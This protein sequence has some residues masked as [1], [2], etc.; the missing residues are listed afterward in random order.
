VITVG[1]IGVGYWG[2]N[3]ANSF[4]AT[5]RATVAWACDTNS[6][7]LAAFAGRHPNIRPTADIKD[8]LKDSN[9]D[10]VAVVTPTV[11]HHA[12]AKAALTAGKHVLV[13]KP[14]TA[15]AAEAEEL[16]RI[17]DETKRVLMVGH[18]FQYNASIIALKE[19]I[20]AGELGDITYLY[21]ERTNLGPVRTDV[22][23]LWDLVSH[24]AY[25]A[26]DLLGDRPAAVNAVGGA[27]LNGTVDDV[28]FATYSFPKGVKAHIHA[29]WL[30]PRKRRQITVVGSRKMAVWDDLDLHEPIRIYDKRVE[31]PPRGTHEGTFME[32]KTMVVDG[33]SDVIRVNLNQPLQAEC[34]HF[35]DCVEKGL[36]PRSDGRFGLAVVQALDAAD[37]SMRRNGVSVSI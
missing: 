14:I 15:S 20:R 2:P 35:I 5:G 32:Y 11:T 37:Q 33:G 34:E 24:D 25:I 30:N 9:V 10:S 16:I 28:V 31:L 22:S 6:E 21:L 8:V 26:M 1:L 12:I 18:V 17:A 13:E 19:L 7:V 36:S 29:S 27:Y 4:K 3:V 23:A